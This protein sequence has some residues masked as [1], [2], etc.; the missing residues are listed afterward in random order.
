[1]E[2]RQSAALN[3]VTNLRHTAEVS[4]FLASLD[5]PFKQEIL[6]IREVI[7]GA[8]AGITEGI[9][10][11]APSFRTT[12]F[13][14]TFNLHAK[15][16]VQVILHRGAKVRD[17]DAQ[18]HLPVADPSGMLEWLSKDRAS[19]KLHSMADIEERRAALGS[20]ISAWIRHV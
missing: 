10:W 20:L 8:D 5:H 13:F 16:C 1:V 2:T 9:K 12:E 11:K 14:A 7:L 4:A 3:A 18:E 19:V 15:G 6:V 17:R